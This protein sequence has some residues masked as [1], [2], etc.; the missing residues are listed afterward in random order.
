MGPIGVRNRPNRI[1]IKY[2][3]I[4]IRVKSRCVSLNIIC[5]NILPG[6]L[7]YQHIQSDYDHCGSHRFLH[8][9]AA[10]QFF[11]KDFRVA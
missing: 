7:N 9:H 10:A 6:N 1:I 2:L 4:L 8:E 3:Q 5:F 11:F